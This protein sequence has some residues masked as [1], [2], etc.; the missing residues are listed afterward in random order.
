MR[1]C[2]HSGAPIR[3]PDVVPVL[4]AGPRPA[5][6]RR[7]LRLAGPLAAALVMAALLGPPR[8][9]AGG[10]GASGRIPDA[11]VDTLIHTDQLLL[12]S[13]G[14]D[15]TVAVALGRFHRAARARSD[16]QTTR[17]ADLNVAH[18]A[19]A[20]QDAARATVG[21]DTTTLAA[22]AGADDR[23][24]AAVATDRRQLQAL[25]VGWY[26]GGASVSPS[27][28]ESLAAAQSAGTADTELALVTRL[29]SATLGRDVEHAHVVADQLTVARGALRNAHAAL[30]TDVRIAD[31]AATVVSGIDRLLRADTAAVAS[32]AVDLDAAEATRARL[33]ASFDGSEG[34]G[35]APV[36]TILGP[37]ALTAAEMAAWFE[38]SGDVAATSATIGALTSRYISE[39]RAEGVRGDIA[40]AQAVVETGDFDSLDAVSLNNYAGVGHC[41]SCHAG[42]R[43]SSP[44]AGIRSQIQLLRTYADA[45]LTS[46]DLPS[47][48][49]LAIL[50]PQRQRVRGC[51]RTWNS[52]TGVWATDPEYGTTVLAVY[53]EMLSF[54]VSQPAPTAG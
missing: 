17:T 4:S 18:H 54:A 30:V 48:P 24:V 10:A 27:L 28:T 25:A 43:F 16:D 33:I 23:A 32:A 7:R 19:G 11:A 15:G 42:L 40:F 5:G 36:P 22:V 3:Q 2:P 49:P 35:P 39:G 9:A 6:R 37:S 1:P 51:C 29:T 50:A 13:R 47:P 38:A 14:A 20:V 12:I 44:L 52:L 26:T 31:H 8:A 46:A 45:T 41:D 53:T 21:R 34:R